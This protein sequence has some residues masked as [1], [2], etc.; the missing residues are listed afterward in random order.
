MDSSSYSLSDLRSPLMLTAVL[1][2]QEPAGQGVDTVH[3]EW[4]EEAGLQVDL[5][6][7]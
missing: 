1:S 5:E 4:H 2:A 3:L 7:S 6:D